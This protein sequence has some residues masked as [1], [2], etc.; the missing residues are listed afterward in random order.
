M[1]VVYKN[2][3]INCIVRISLSIYFIFYIIDGI[4]CFYMG[5]FKFREV[6]KLFEILL[7]L[8]YRVRILNGFF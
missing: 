3:K 1:E 5:K 7:L 8:R 4:R 6:R 2:E